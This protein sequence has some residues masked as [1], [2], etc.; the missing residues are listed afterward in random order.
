MNKKTILYLRTDLS[1][2]Q[3]TAGGSVAH[4]LGVIG[5]FNQLGYKVMC[6]SS[7]MQSVLEKQHLEMLISLKNPQILSFL[8]WKINCFLS[9]FFFCVP[10]LF[11]LKNRSVL[12]IYQRY[13]LLNITG[14]LIAWWYKKK[15]ILEYNGSEVWI[16]T[17][18]VQKKRWM[19]LTWLMEKVEMWNLHYAD[20]VVV[21]SEALKSEL[22]QKGVSPSKILVNPNGVDPEQYNPDGKKVENENYHNSN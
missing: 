10:I 3:L 20:L 4:T 12:F 7:C 17:H 11:K 2:E 16:A 15:L 18:W 1:N 22:L 19:K 13:S 14:L 21:V 8:R 9:S 6:A 5:G